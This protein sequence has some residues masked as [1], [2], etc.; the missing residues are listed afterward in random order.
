MPVYS[1]ENSRMNL[2]NMCNYKLLVL[3]SVPG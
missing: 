1:F 3:I 2:Y